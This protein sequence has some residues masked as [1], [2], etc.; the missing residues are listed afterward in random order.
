MILLILPLL[1]LLLLGS[2]LLPAPRPEV[3]LL[4]Q[5][6]PAVEQ[7]LGSSLEASEVGMPSVG[8]IDSQ[9]SDELSSEKSE[10]EGIGK[11]DGV[12]ESPK[13]SGR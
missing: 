3:N 12:K 10:E 6:R 5:D 2:L 9:A 1:P 13:K 7:G 4:P 11:K 8:E